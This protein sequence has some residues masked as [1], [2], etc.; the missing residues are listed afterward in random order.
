ML[1]VPSLDFDSCRLLI[2]S[3]RVRRYLLLRKVLDSLAVHSVPAHDLEV[4]VVTLEKDLLVLVSEVLD[5]N[6]LD[7]GSESVA[8]IRDWGPSTSS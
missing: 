8:N 5:S 2:L 1:E 4:L 3:S 7:D 6:E